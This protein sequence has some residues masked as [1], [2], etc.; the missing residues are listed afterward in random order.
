MITRLQVKKSDWFTHEAIEEVMER[1]GMKFCVTVIFPDNE[2][3]RTYDVACRPMIEEGVLT[4][5]YFDMTAHDFIHHI[6][7][8][9]RKMKD[10]DIVD[11]T[12]D[13]IIGSIPKILM[14]RGWEL[15]TMH[16]SRGDWRRV[17]QVNHYLRAYT[18]KLPRGLNG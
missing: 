16:Y 2:P 13:Q 7:T 5:S 6:A 14:N 17:S 1:F 8:E 4:V 12:D 3:P 15:K 9:L 10:E 18:H 11:M